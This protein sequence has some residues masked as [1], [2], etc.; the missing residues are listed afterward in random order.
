MPAA[1]RSTIS[2]AAVRWAEQLERWA[3][4]EKILAQAPEK[5]G[6]TIVTLLNGTVITAVSIL[7]DPDGRLTIKD[8]Q[9]KVRYINPIDIRKRELKPAK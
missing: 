6:P 9:G 4:P 8:D 3:I 2:D 7:Q 5:E 1:G